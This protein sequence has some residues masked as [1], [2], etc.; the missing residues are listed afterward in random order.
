[1]KTPKTDQTAP[2]KFKPIPAL[3]NAIATTELAL[4]LEAA[5]QVATKLGET[6]MTGAEKLSEPMHYLSELME[7]LGNEG[8]DVARSEVL[9]AHA[10]LVRIQRE[11]WQPFA[12]LG[13]DRDED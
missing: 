1:M 7:T 13:R 2:M 11:L 12:N 5:E 8:N 10:A 9:R 3:N 4:K 6:V